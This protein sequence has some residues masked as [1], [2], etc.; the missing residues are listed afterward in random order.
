M[1]L[2]EIL[3]LEKWVEFE[4][5]IHESPGLDVNSDFEKRQA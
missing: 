1:K 5:E 4:N 3:P 2:A